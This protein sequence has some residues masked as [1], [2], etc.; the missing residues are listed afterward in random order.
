VGVDD[1]IHVGGGNVPVP[2]SV[3]IDHEIRP[4]FA[5]IQAP[6][7]VGSHTALQ[8]PLFELLFEELLQ[9]GF[10]FGIAASARMSGRPLIA[11]EKN[12]LLELRH[13]DTLAAFGRQARHR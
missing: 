10:A 5:L 3:G 7:L 11:A 1:F 12:V 2:D 9:R 4:M 6:G 13:G 8:S